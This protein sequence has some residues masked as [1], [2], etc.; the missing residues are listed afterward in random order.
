MTPSPVR[1]CCRALAALSAV[2]ALA[3]YPPGHTS[4]DTSGSAG[5]LFTCRV[6]T[7]PA[8]VSA[9]INL[10]IPPSREPV[11]LAQEL[12]LPAPLSSIRLGLFIP[13]SKCKQSFVPEQGEDA[14]SGIEISIDGPSQSYQQWLIAGNPE[15]NRL[16]SLIGNWRYM[17]VD[18]IKQR[19]QLFEQFAKELTRE[20]T[21]AI[22]K[23]NGQAEHQFP[24]K[25]GET[26]T[27]ADLNCS[28][29][30]RE[31]FPHF[32]IDEA[33]GKPINFSEKQENPAVLV[34]IRHEGRTEERWVFARFADFKADEFE[35]LPFRITI[36]CPSEKTNDLP[37][38]AIVSIGDTGHELWTHKDD[39]HLSRPIG[40]RDRIEIKPTDYTFHV[41]RFVPAGRL[42]ETYVPTDQK[43]GRAALQI[44]TFD[45]NG[46][47]VEI[48]LEK[49]KSRVIPTALG[50]MTIG[51]GPRPSECPGGS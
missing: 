40:L 38:F 44:G 35:R 4:R 27:F 12:E 2:S 51:F 3:A 13:K 14:H 10:E 8:P 46:N 23:L 39:K 48:W 41:S 49:G 47:E 36:Q 33:S 21:I 29:R 7:L 15:R 9:E 37:N 28:V 1:F 50:P 20:P 32:V 34:E 30:V 45:G 43:V 16:I 24:L 6:D 19:N 42:I 18:G 26:K 25:I 22:S 5:L 17:A 31:Y 11:D